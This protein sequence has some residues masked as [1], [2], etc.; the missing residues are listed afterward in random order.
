[1]K[2]VVFLLTVSAVVAL[3]G[4]PARAD[5]VP[6]R[7]TGIWSVT[8]CGS[9]GLTVLLES[10][11][12]MMFE[13]QSER[14]RVAM[15]RAEWLAGSIALTIEGETD[16]LVLSALDS[17]ARCDA[18]PGSF[19]LLFAEAITFF[20]RFDEIEDRFASEDVAAV[21]CVSF[22][23]DIIDVSG[24][25]VFPPAE[26]SRAVRAAG[27]FFGYGLAVEKL[28]Y[29]A[30]DGLDREAQD[31]G[32]DGAAR[33]GDAAVRAGGDGRRLSWRGA[34]RRQAGPWRGG[35]D[36]L[37]GGGFNQFRGTPAKGEAGAGQGFPQARDRARR[38]A[39]A[40]P[41]DG[42]CDRRPGLWS[43]LDEAAC[44]HR[45]IRTGSRRQAVRMALFKWVDTTLGNIKSAITG[46][47][48]KLGPDHAERYLA[49]FAWRYNRRY[50]LQ[51]MIPRF[52]HSA[53][54]T[55]PMPYRLLIA[56]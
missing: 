43:A 40:G 44:S 56:G 7:V 22:V 30:A 11:A 3:A 1:M 19:S 47:Y 31:H 49:S 26:L 54:R 48:R 13:G 23:F 46:T 27:F 52:I 42:G 51:T 29:E 25:G 37:R 24:D 28:Q 34:L 41:W 2:L 50:Q 36:A 39:L 38:Q 53:A 10:N 55:E 32:G 35:Q 18:P 45:A 4:L 21:R 9:G 5:P 12:A 8:A 14:S 15:A 33:K 20:R 17:L 6:D 16:E